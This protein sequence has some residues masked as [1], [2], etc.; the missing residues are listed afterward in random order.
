MYAND[1]KNIL[2]D[3]CMM[4]FLQKSAN[5]KTS[6]RKYKYHPTQNSMLTRTLENGSQELPQGK[7][8]PA[9]GYD[10][11]LFEFSKKDYLEV[12][13]EKR[14][15]FM[16]ENFKDD[17]KESFQEL[18]KRSEKMLL[19]EH[20]VS[21]TLKDHFDAEKV[22]AIIIAYFTDLGYTVTPIKVLIPMEICVIL[23]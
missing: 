19:C 23:T 1:V 15:Q 12:L 4:L 7:G 17:L 18:R 9:R 11:Q 14:A 13:A 20:T 21:F 10:D 3:V 16:F 22:Q 5:R 6:L 8:Y 2:H